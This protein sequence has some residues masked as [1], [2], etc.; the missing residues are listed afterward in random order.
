MAKEP[1]LCT[2]CE[3]RPVLSGPK[4]HLG[5]MAETCGP[6]TADKVRDGLCPKCHMQADECDHATAA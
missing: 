5:L 4:K 1:T 3:E 2:T 6:C